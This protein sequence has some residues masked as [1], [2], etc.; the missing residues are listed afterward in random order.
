MRLSLRN[1]YPERMGCG[2]AM[3]NTDAAA[4]LAEWNE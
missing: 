1:F 2:H 4:S 3:G